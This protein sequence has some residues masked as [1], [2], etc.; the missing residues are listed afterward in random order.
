VA[1]SIPGCNE[2]NQFCCVTNST[3]SDKDLYTFYCRFVFRGFKAGMNCVVQ[4]AKLLPEH[5]FDTS[6]DDAVSICKNMEINKPAAPDN[7]KGKLIK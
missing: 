1:H 4:Y 7:I 5:T 6:K 3:E 2:S